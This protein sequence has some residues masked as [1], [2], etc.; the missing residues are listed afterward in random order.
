[1]S[2]CGRRPMPRCGSPTCCGPTS[3]RNISRRRWPASQGGSDA[4]AGDNAVSHGAPPPAPSNLPVR[5]A[6]AAVMLALA[7]LALALG[8]EILDIFIVVVALAVFVEFVL[9]VVRATA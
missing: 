6:S 4:M 1:T 7:G 9:L 8:G 2:C 3:R 5:L